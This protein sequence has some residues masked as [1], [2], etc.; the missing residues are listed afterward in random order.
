MGFRKIILES[1][2]EILLGRDAKSND[3]LLKKFK[4]KENKILHTIAAGSPFCVINRLKPSKEDINLS[5]AHC[6]KRSQ[7]WRDNKGDIK[8]HLFDGK[9]IKKPFFRKMGTWQITKKPKVIKI[10]K[11]EIEKL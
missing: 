1:G 4:G 9:S 5:G 10:K 8:M 11:R 3:D 2:A 6:A 7:D